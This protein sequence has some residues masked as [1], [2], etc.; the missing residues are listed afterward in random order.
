MSEYNIQFRTIDQY[1]K[2]VLSTE[3]GHET[4]HEDTVKSLHD[5]MYIFQF[6]YNSLFTNKC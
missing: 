3:T 4:L 2:H 1:H 6:F 5:I